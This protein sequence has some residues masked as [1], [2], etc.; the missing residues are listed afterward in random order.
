MSD[1]AAVCLFNLGSCGVGRYHIVVVQQDTGTP[2]R[3]SGGQLEL[4]RCKVEKVLSLA[5]IGPACR[6]ERASE[7]GTPRNNV[8]TPT[9]N[10]SVYPCD[11][12]VTLVVNA[13]VEYAVSCP[14][15]QKPARVSHQPCKPVGSARCDERSPSLNFDLSPAHLAV[16]LRP[17]YNF[18]TYALLDNLIRAGLR[19]QHH[20]YTLYCYLRTTSLLPEAV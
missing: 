13:Q 19:D 4:K 1:R 16:L 20:T 11:L 12:M 15:K 17:C 7:Q 3:T 18:H 5:W 2:S 14:R 6:C 9:V 10:V 8:C